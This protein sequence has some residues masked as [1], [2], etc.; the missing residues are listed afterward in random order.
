MLSQEAQLIALVSNERMEKSDA[1]VC[2]EGDDGYIR[3]Q[4]AFEL[5]QN[6]LAPLIVVSGGVR[7]PLSLP[8]EKM[9]GYLL[10][11][12]LKKNN[13]ILESVSQNTRQQALEVMKIVKEKKLKKNHFSCFYFPPAKGIFNFFKS[14]K[15]L[16]CKC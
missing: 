8:A 7:L 15:R 11:K 3:I 16:S 1:I 10:K 13:I 4:K 5:F 6:K 9:A 12:G 2:L 14:G